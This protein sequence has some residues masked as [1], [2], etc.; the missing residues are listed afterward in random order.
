MRCS[1]SSCVPNLDTHT[2]GAPQSVLQT[3]RQTFV[4]VKTSPATAT[5]LL[6]CC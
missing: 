5:L 1:W 2:S 4:P 3:S 6:F